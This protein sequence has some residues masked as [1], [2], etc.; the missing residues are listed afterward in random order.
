MIPLRTTGG[1]NAVSAAYSAQKIVRESGCVSWDELLADIG[2]QGRRIPPLEVAYRSTAEIMR[3]SQDV[4]GPFAGEPPKA[5]RHGAPVELHRFSDPG[6][7]VGF[8][9]EALRDLAVREPSANVAI[10]A[11]HLGQARTYYQG[12][13][14]AEIPRLNIV[15]VEDFSFGPGV[16][17]TEVHQVK[18]LEFDYVI[19]VDVNADSYP[20]NEDSRHLL[21]VAATRAAHQLWIVSTGTPSPILPAWLL[22]DENQ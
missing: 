7:A 19:L 16:E 17:A 12:L 6:Q 20:D 22:K 1:E 15:A 2:V 18:G 9:A 8:L 10:I 21:H 14:K 5:V 3:L 11:R 4:L 13:E